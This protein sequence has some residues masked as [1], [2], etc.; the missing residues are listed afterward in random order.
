MLSPY[1]FL[2]L[3]VLCEVAATSA[4]KATEGFTK[5][6]PSVVC[7]VGYGFAFYFL[8]Q[9]LRHMSVGV[10][11]AL[12]CA[13]G[14]VLVALIGWLWFKQALDIAAIAGMVLILAGVVLISFY[15][16]TAVH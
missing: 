7:V 9:C 13:G 3:A 6:I 10:A 16:K 8:S 2:T 1:V 4:L 12:W 14:I 15:S 5:L 11:Y